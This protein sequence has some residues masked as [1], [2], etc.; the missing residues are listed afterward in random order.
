MTAADVIAALALPP[1]SRVD[2]R[3]PKKLLVDNGAPTAADKRQIND[4]IEELFWV[5]ALKPGSIGVPQYRDATREI[6]EIAILSLVLRAGAK[7]ARLVELVHRAIPYPVFLIAAQADCVSLS[8][9]SKRWA[10]N[11]AG[12]TVLESTGSANPVV[13]VQLRSAA[14]GLE[15][16]FL[17]GL[18]LSAQPRSHLFALYCAWIARF[19]AFQAAQITGRLAVPTDP[20]VQEARRRALVEHARLQGEI[21]ALRAQAEKEKQ[22]NRRVE[23]NLNLKRLEAALAEATAS[24]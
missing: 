16:S 15:N 20:A 12:K 5:A 3:V 9:A 11:E 23:M 24:L 2:Q 10:E 6:L 21:A 18:A 8:L 13:S 17:T 19:E 4:G 22:I 7:V 1:E 14:D